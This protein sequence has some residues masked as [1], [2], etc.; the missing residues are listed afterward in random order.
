[1]RNNDIEVDLITSDFSHRDKTYRNKSN[2]EH[3]KYIHEPAYNK[4]VSL[5]RFYCHHI[6]A[7]NIKKYL[8]TIEKPDFIYCSVP[9]LEVGKVVAKFAS[10][11]S[12]ELIIDIQDLWPEAFEM[13]FNVPI[14]S[15]IIFYPMKI[16]ANYIYKNANKIIAVSDTYKNRA[17]KVNH[18]K[19]GLTVFLGTDLTELNCELKE[20]EMAYEKQQNEVWIGYIGTIGNSYDIETAL[21]SIKIVQEKNKNI[22]FILL[23]DGPYVEKYKKMAKD[24]SIN[25]VFLGRK[26]YIEAMK[27][28]SQ[29]DIALNPLVKGAAQSI[30]N[31]VGD[32]AALGLP[33]VNSLQNNEYKELLKKYNSGIN[34]GCEDPS[35]MAK[36]IMEIVEDSDRKRIMA[37]NSMKMGKELFDRKKTYVKIINLIKY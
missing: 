18:N 4:N 3:I 21:N 34:V 31:K 12:I 22:K 2:N 11:N 7:N 27:I 15:D 23:G 29:C 9:S 6:F 20:Q 19:D 32:Y 37:N 8:M 10:E 30:I 25:A 5:R 35:S 24:L 16:S 36:A 28:L 13:V 1:M 26:P 33:V 17:L 14:V